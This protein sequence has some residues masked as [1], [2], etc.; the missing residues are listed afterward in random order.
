MTTKTPNIFSGS[1]V[2]LWKYTPDN[3][4]SLRVGITTITLQKKDAHI[5][6]KQIRK[7]LDNLEAS[8]K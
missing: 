3:S 6:F 1:W 8:E 4:I 2:Q 7:A 5:V